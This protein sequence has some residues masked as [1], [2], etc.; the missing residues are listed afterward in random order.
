[1]YY[2]YLD[3]RFYTAIFGL[4]IAIHYNLLLHFCTSSAFL[5]WDLPNFLV[6][7]I[8]ICTEFSFWLLHLTRTSKADVLRCATLVVFYVIFNII[9]L[10]TK[11]YDIINFYCL[12]PC[13]RT[14]IIIITIRFVPLR[15]LTRQI[16]YSIWLFSLAIVV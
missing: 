10:L 2:F 9:A 14:T 5:I 15:Q 12:L 13:L 3:I 6:H 8:I 4:L 16:V 1:M 11:T 7:S